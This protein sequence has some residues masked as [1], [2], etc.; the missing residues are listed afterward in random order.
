[1]K[2]NKWENYLSKEAMATGSRLYHFIE[3]E[4]KNGSII[5]PPQNCIFKALKLTKPKDVKVVII[6][7]DPYHEEGQANGLAFSVNPGIAIP[8]S[9]NNIFKELHNDIG[10]DIPTNGDLTK[11]AQRGILLLNRT[12]TV[13]KGAPNSHSGFGWGAF[14]FDVVIACLLLPQPIVFLLWGKQAKSFTHTIDF[15][16]YKNKDYYATSHPSP[17]SATRGSM[18]TP[19]F[20]GSRPFS[21][22]NR[23]LK[24]MGGEPIDWSL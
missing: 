1:M 14:V 24:Q 7:Q 17:L 21:T 9:L 8:P 18:N 16:E 5:Y 19:A 13:E 12:L 22:A 11:W 3:K 15:S 10:C 20:I 23:L 6:G 4:R 2:M